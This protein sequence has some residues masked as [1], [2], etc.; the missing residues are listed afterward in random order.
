MKMHAHVGHKGLVQID[1]ETL[2]TVAIMMEG[3]AQDE[4]LARLMACAPD[5]LE[6]LELVLKLNEPSA[7]TVH[8]KEFVLRNARAVIAKAKGGQ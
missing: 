6:A 7:M 2:H 4:K 5:L 1:D 8:E 3:Y